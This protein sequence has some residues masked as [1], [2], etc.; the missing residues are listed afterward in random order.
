MT[1]RLAEPA[2]VARVIAMGTRFAD[3]SSYAA[4]FGPAD[5][6]KVAA[7]TARLALSASA[8]VF[9]A[10]QAGVVI[11]VIAGHLYDHPMFTDVRMASEVIWWVEPEHRTGRTAVRL[12]AAFEQ[13]ADD[14]G[15]THVQ[16]IAWTD[17]VGEFYG[18]RHYA[19][20]ESAFV[21]RL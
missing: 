21:R 16:M 1:V 18:R 4:I 11:G 6:D 7:L 2:D 14:H 19:R 9:V 8:C 5:A 10:E 15:A 17:R 20:G 3:E 12:L 13:W